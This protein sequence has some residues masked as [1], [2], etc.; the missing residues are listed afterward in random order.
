MI[1]KEY[2]LDSRGGAYEAC[3]EIQRTIPCFLNVIEAYDEFDFFHLVI[4]C[5]QEDLPYV[6]RTIAE[7]V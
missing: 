6:E 4:K 5:R 2:M 1:T 3:K 7:F